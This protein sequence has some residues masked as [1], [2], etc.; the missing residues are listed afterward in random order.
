ETILCGGAF[1]TP[2]LLMLSGV[3]PRRELEDHGLKV[4]V[5]LPGVGKNLQ[6]RYEISVVN[7]MKENW[8]LLD[9]ATFSK[10]DRQYQQWSQN[11][12]GVYATNGG[13][14]AVVKKS[15]RHR[16]PDLFCLGLLGKF[17]GYFPG[18]SK[19]IA[20]HQNYLSWIVLKAHTTNTA[21]T[22]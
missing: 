18:Y 10:G 7:R 21:G 13:V 16:L 17:K 2:Q 20:D 22:V 9:G 11:N 4:R 5:D 12:Q 3:G 8:K 15:Q 19:L 1:N 14:L 6:D